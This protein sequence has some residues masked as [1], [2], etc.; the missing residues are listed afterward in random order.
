M[1]YSNIRWCFIQESL[2]YV[3]IP[4]I[5]G[6]SVAES[7]NFFFSHSSCPEWVGW[8]AGGLFSLKFLREQADKD[9]IFSCCYCLCVQWLCASTISA[10]WKENTRESN[11]GNYVHSLEVPFTSA[12]ISL[13]KIWSYVT[14]EEIAVS[15]NKNLLNFSNA[16]SIGG[17]VEFFWS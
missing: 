13:A 17:F 6:I 7:N 10:L 1:P 4:N 9:S 12:H 3:V 16:K 15:S 2:G 11:A 8:W 5:L 14:L